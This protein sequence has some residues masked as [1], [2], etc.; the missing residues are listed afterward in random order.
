MFKDMADTT[1]KRVLIGIDWHN[2]RFNLSLLEALRERGCRLIGWLPNTTSKMQSPDVELFGS[3]KTRRGKLEAQWVRE[4]EKKVDRYAKIKIPGDAMAETF[5]YARFKRGAEK[6][7]LRPIN[8]EILLQDQAASDGDVLAHNRNVNSALEPLSQ[9]P[10]LR[11]CAE[12]K[13]PRFSHGFSA[14]NEV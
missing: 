7:G 1:G 14:T 4:N 11:G 12:R 10:R 3:F 6:V 5:T 8:K 2:S 13:L 9:D